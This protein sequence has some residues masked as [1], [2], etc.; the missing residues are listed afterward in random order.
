MPQQWCKRSL[1]RLLLRR[2]QKAKIM[3]RQIIQLRIRIQVNREWLSRCSSCRVDRDNRSD[4]V[5]RAKWM[6]Q[7]VRRVLLSNRWPKI[8][9][10]MLWQIRSKF[11]RLQMLNRTPSNRHN[12]RLSRSNQRQKLTKPKLLSLT[13]TSSQISTQFKIRKRKKRKRRWRLPRKLWRKLPKLL[14]RRHKLWR[15]P[16]RTLKKSLFQHR[17]LHRAKRLSLRCLFSRMYQ[18]Y[19]VARKRRSRRVLWKI[20]ATTRSQ[21]PIKPIQTFHHLPTSSRLPSMRS[22]MPVVTINKLRLRRPQHREQRPQLSRHHQYR[23][24]CQHKMGNQIHQAH[25]S[26][27]HPQKTMTTLLR[28]VAW[29]MRKNRW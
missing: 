20:I 2:H 16:L 29:P 25:P 18:Q 9:F 15:R 22:S 27:S 10:K 8:N 26:L 11:K 17:L 12:L 3:A 7:M 24:Q 23:R 28:P 14:R 4:K 13:N 5:S 1:W 19:K 21:S 6:W